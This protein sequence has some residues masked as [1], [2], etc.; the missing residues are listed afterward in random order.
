LLFFANKSDLPQAYSESD[1]A[2]HMQLEKI[3]DRPWHIQASSA[4]T[5]MGV[6]E[7]MNW[8]TEMI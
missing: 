7:G 6:N 5:G 4:T 3:T 2:G 1:I 8:L